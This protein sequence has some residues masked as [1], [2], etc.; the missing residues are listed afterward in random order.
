M[1]RRKVKLGLYSLTVAEMIPYCR[2]I[3]QK[4]TG[5]PNFPTPNPDLAVVAAAVDELSA[6]DDAAEDRSNSS[7]KLVGIKKEGVFAV[8]RPLRDY[9]NIEGNGVEEILLSSGFPLADL[10][11]NIVLT[12]PQNLRTKTMDKL[13]KGVVRV[14]CDRVKGATGYQ[15]RYRLVNQIL[16]SDSAVESIERLDTWTYV[17][18]MSTLSQIIRGLRSAE[19]YEFQMRSIGSGQ[20]SGWSESKLG[21]SA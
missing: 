3:I 20:P 14:K 2:F 13:G 5:N 6:A 11:S 17:D 19:Y 16:D 10:P 4:M 7:I 8:M 1:V 18:P 21:L 9:V 15:V 12:V